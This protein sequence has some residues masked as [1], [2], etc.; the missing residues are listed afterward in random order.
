MLLPLLAR[1]GGREA[2]GVVVQMFKDLRVRY[3][4]PPSF[5]LRA[6]AEGGI[7]ELRANSVYSSIQTVIVCGFFEQAELRWNLG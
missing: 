1:R 3:P 7:T 5:Q 6:A 2:A 4:S